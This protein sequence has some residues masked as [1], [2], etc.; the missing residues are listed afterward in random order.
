MTCSTRRVRSCAEF[1]NGAGVAVRK[2]C[3]PSPVTS[4]GHDHD[5]PA[6][7]EHRQASNVENGQVTSRRRPNEYRAITW[8][9]EENRVVQRQQRVHR[10]GERQTCPHRGRAGPSGRRRHPFCD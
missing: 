9:E 4:L 1:V 5:M 6:R 10:S 2:R 7:R 8:S 3:D